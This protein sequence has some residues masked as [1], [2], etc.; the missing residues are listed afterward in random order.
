MGNRINGI[1]LANDIVMPY[2]GVEEALGSYCAADRISKIDFSYNYSHENPFPVGKNI[3]SNEV[4]ESF[5]FVF[6]QAADFL[7]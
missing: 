4:D 2:H 6:S 5:R 3:D 1:S 7:E